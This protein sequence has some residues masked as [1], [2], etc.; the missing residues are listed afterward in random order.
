MAELFTVSEEDMKQRGFPDWGNWRGVSSL[1]KEHKDIVNN[2][3]LA[4][5]YKPIPVPSLTFEGLTRLFPPQHAHIDLLHVDTEGYDANIVS[6]ALDF[7]EKTCA[8][9]RHI[10]W[11]WVHV[12]MPEQ[13][14]L[15]KRL[16]SSGYHCFY[17]N[18][19]VQ[20]TYSTCLGHGGLMWLER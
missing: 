3:R 20:C 9:P 1:S 4:E 11:E 15:L 10:K 16:A 2:P 17:K 7:A 19:D 5:F 18:K 8:Y 14:T 12:T 13:R 6:Q